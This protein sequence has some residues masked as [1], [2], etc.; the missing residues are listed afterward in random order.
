MYK[1]QALNA[2]SP[3][4]LNQFPKDKYIISNEI[5]DP[6]AILVRSYDLHKMA[7]PSSVEVIGRAGAGV[8]NIPVAALTKLGIPV[9]NTPGANS[10]AVRELVIAGMLLASRNIFR[11][12]N[13]VDQ[14]K[15]LDGNFDKQVEQDKKQFVGYEL[16]GKTIGVIGL[17][18]VG[19]KVA[20][21][22]INLG[23]HA[24]GYDPAI[25]VHRAWELSSLVKQATSIEQ[26][27]AHSDFIS[28]HVPL[29]EQTRKLINHDRLHMMKHGVVILNFAR[30][31]IVDNEAIIQA[32][33]EKKL[34]AY[35]CDFPSATLL[36][37]PH[38]ISLPHLGA[39]TKEAEEN[40][41][42]MIVD[43]VKR[44][45]EEGTII[46]SVNFPSTESLTRCKVRL[47]IVN[48]N[49]PN[50]VAQ[51]S[52]ALGDAHLNIASLINKSNDSIAY[53]IIDL[54]DDVTNETL[55][56]IKNINGIIR[57][58]KIIFQE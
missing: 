18:N 2:I 45:L 47:T 38:V 4:G 57:A 30:H 40:C 15:P 13:Y 53:T 27:I 22:A 42:V 6:D 9:L 23:M 20:N 25:T 39:S 34:S 36:K 7:I 5:Q 55:D 28:L 1:I 37:V 8:N 44:F 51:I 49:I 26:V 29:S 11:A 52:S 31:E 16:L 58:R 10:N 24:I 12:L 48:E 19:V 41:A 17:G 54:N 46:N 43:Q 32:I 33:A 50:M 35:V 56:K 3:A 14:L 21:A